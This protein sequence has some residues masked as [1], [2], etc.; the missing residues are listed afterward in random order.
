ML[1][2]TICYRHFYSSK[3]ERS[4]ITTGCFKFSNIA[5]V[6]CLQSDNFVC[7][8]NPN[9]D[10]LQ[11]EYPKKA[12]GITFLYAF[13]QG[14]FPDKEIEEFYYKCQAK[15]FLRLESFMEKHIYF[16]QFRHFLLFRSSVSPLSEK[17]EINKNIKHF[18]PSSQIASNKRAGTKRNPNND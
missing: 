17:Q 7:Q 1:L 14:Y 10:L 8:F 13:A 11:F 5:I 2:A 6:Q 4:T 12:A 18:K 15:N 16:H 9:S 3:D